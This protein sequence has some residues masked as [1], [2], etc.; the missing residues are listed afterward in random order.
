[1]RIG[2]EAT[3]GGTSAQKLAETLI[4]IAAGGLQRRSRRNADGLDEQVYLKPLVHL[5]AAGKS[6]ADRLTEGLSNQRENL[7][8]EIL[9]RTRL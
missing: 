4:E 2:L 1:V 7:L 8:R 9:E 6:P 5:V 3:I